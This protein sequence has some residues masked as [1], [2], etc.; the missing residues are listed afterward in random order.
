MI[1]RFYALPACGWIDSD[2]ARM[3][4]IAGWF[5]DAIDPDGK[6]TLTTAIPPAAEYSTREGQRMIRDVDKQVIRFE[7]FDVDD[8]IRGLYDQI[9]RFLA[10]DEKTLETIIG[11]HRGGLVPAVMLSHL[12]NVKMVPLRWQTRDQDKYTDHA[13]LCKILYGCGRD[14]AILVVDDIA[15]SGKTLNDIRRH[16]G[17]CD[18]INPPSVYYAA[19]V[20]KTTAELDMPILSDTVTGLDDW[21][22]FP[23]E[24]E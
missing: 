7:W 17:F 3:R 5:W 1:R 22:H 15:D 10:K 8:A 6:D 4:S 2:R 13:E 24:A 9:Q 14:D 19:L 11:V 12:F 16:I 21:I 20:E 18:A 23:W